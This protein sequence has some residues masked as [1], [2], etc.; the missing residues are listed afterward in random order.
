MNEAFKYRYHLAL[1]LAALSYTS[2]S[3]STA[4]LS[5]KGFN[6]FNQIFWI[7]LLSI[8]FAGFFAFYVF[9]ESW[10]INLKEFQYLLV[11][12]LIFLGAFTTFCLAIYFGTPIAKAVALNYAYP[13]MVIALSYFL[14]NELPS[15]KHWISVILSLISVL[16][17]IQVW[18]IKN[19]FDIQIGELM[20]FANSFFYGAIIVFGKKLKEDT[21]LSVF[22][23]L[24][25]AELFMLPLFILMSFIL[26]LVEVEALSPEL[27]LVFPLNV[28]LVLFVTSI[29]GGLLPLVLIYYGTSKV[30]PY[31]GGILLLTEPIWVYICGLLFFEQSLSTWGILGSIGIVFSVFLI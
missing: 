31:V 10:K 3:V 7:T 25:Y 11:N 5:E 9:R 2:L 18:T 13:L 21:G 14:L 6:A 8:I 30:K 1:L 22:K 15:A 20:A 28:W 17:L 4:W 19:L 24:F 16:V 26:K 27:Q 12:A 29:T 23:S